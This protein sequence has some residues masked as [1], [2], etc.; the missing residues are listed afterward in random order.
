MSVQEFE[1]LAFEEF[2]MAGKERVKV[3]VAWAVRLSVTVGE[4]LWADGCSHYSTNSRDD[5]ALFSSRERAKD[6]LRHWSRVVSEV[7]T[8]AR[9]DAPRIVR[10]TFYE[11]RRG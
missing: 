5:R 3:G 4:T 7:E 10:V 2:T 11:V 9:P 8:S 1:R 6:V